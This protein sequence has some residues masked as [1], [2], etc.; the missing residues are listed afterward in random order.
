MEQSPNLENI[1]IR[2]WAQQIRQIKINELQQMIDL[3]Q[4]TLKCFPEDSKYYGVN[5]ALYMAETR[6]KI[7]EKIIVLKNKLQIIQVGHVL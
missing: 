2:A 4:E 1:D 3:K 6:N 7:I 5:I